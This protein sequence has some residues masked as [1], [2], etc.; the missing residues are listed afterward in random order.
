MELIYCRKWM[1]VFFIYFINHW[2]RTIV[3]KTCWN[4]FIIFSVQWPC[5]QYFLVCGQRQLKPKLNREKKPPSTSFSTGLCEPNQIVIWLRWIN[6]D[7]RVSFRSFGME[8]QKKS[9]LY[10]QNDL[11][12][13]ISSFPILVWSIKYRKFELTRHNLLG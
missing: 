2:T 4:N 3:G 1:F 8:K 13:S 5:T 9:E 10:V 7:I 12:F 6:L 11:R